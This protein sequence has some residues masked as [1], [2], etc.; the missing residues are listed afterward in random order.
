MDAENIP[1][2]LPKSNFPSIETTVHQGSCKENLLNHACINIFRII[3]N[4]IFNGDIVSNDLKFDLVT[5]NNIKDEK[6]KCK[7][8]NNTD[9]ICN[10]HAKTH[11]TSLY[12]I[13]EVLG[14]VGHE[15]GHWKQ[16]HVIWKVFISMTKISILILAFALLNTQ[17]ALYQAF[18]F[19]NG[20]PLLIG[21][22]IIY[23]WTLETLNTIANFLQKTAERHFEY[24][25]DDYA[26]NI[27][28][29]NDL[30][31]ALIKIHMENLIYPKDD[32]LYTAWFKSHPTLL[33]RLN[34]LQSKVN[35]KD[36]P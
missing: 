21:I 22:I 5:K 29:K 28:L 11:V 15:L 13:D 24:E 4:T 34:C 27:G 31:K 6:Y 16:G 33:Q 8:C 25:A 23:Y 10:K 12:T 20:K 19:M 7:K 26:T 35:I 17:D 14:I 18:D 1:E 36:L 9:A 32:C 3:S 2:M 30:C